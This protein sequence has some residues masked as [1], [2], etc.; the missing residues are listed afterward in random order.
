MD[1]PWRKD[2]FVQRM[3][4]NPHGRVAGG[5]RSHC[6][7][8]VVPG[9][10][11]FGRRLG[12]CLI[13][14]STCI[15]LF[16]MSP[17]QLCKAARRYVRPHLAEPPKDIHARHVASSATCQREEGDIGKSL[18]ETTPEILKQKVRLP[19]GGAREVRDRKTGSKS[20]PL[21]SLS[22]SLGR[23]DLFGLRE[24]GGEI[25]RN[26]LGSFPGGHIGQKLPNPLRSA[27]SRSQRPIEP[28]N[29]RSAPQETQLLSCV[30]PVKESL[31]RRE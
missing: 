21:R 2:H 24:L 8:A 27:S 19:L 1:M 5:L 3:Q 14:P 25:G 13:C 10:G 29:P 18:P 6:Q 12:K 17:H 22:S 30:S 15:H 7:E 23:R 11:G 20:P 16:A 4:R 26:S 9:H 28:L 31:R